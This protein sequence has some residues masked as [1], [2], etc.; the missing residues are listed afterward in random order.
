MRFHFARFG[1][2]LTLCAIPMACDSSTSYPASAERVA[3][4]IE[5]NDLTG[6][7]F[8]LSDFRGKVVLLDFWA[9][10]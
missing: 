3:P 10:Y 5:G 6:K 8:K 2:V 1:L 7:P 4:S 9:T